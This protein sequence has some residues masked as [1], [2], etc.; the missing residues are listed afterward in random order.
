MTNLP[1]FDDVT[2]AAARIAPHAFV[3][4]LI[5]SDA[6]NA[7]MGRRV[8]LKLE[9]LQRTGAFKFRGACNRILM[10]PENERARGVVAFSSGNHAQAVAAVAKLFGMSA[11]IVM[12]QD[13]PRAKIDATR[14]HGATVI[15]YDRFK[16]SREEIAGAIQAKSGATLVKPFD[17]PGIVAGQG[18]AGLEIAA[19][20][21]AL[22]AVPDC[23]MAPA[24]GGGLVSGIALAL[25]GTVPGARV[26][27]VEPEN[28]ASMK[29]SLEAGTQVRAAAQPPSQA[30]A[31]MSPFTGDVPFGVARLHM[32]GG[33]GVSDTE[34]DAAMSYAARH[35]K[36]I[37]EPGGSA[38]LAALLT[39]KSPADS[40]CA[41][42]VLSG[43]NADFETVA[44]ACARVPEP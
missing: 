32:K 12:P 9:T 3:T 24:S 37:V 15:L 38:A 33:I 23:V 40:Q 30:D 8:L 17:D 43:G 1:G 4:P 16:E 42:V 41:V 39:N 14:G 10:I 22:G 21:N 19:Q 36:L 2:A 29:L 20:A 7:R 31:L 35:L 6:L 28:F 26:F 13:A 27:S 44:A 25:S 11:T 34:L 18:T 5:E